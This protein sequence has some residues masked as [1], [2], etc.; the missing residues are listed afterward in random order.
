[1]LT[2]CK[3]AAI[4]YLTGDPD[5]QYTPNKKAV[6]NFGIA[7]NRKWKDESGQG[8]EDTMFIDC[9]AWGKVAEL[10]NEHIGKGDPIYIEGHLRLER[11]EGQDG[12]KRSKH[13]ISISHVIFLKPKD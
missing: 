13:T 3:V 10:V 5:L 2:F 9:T 12:T 8:H 11:W 7:I 4:A 6:V 1:M